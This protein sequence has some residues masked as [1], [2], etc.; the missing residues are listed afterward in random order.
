MNMARKDKTEWIL[1]PETERD[2][3]SARKKCRRMVA[4]SAAIS[5]GVSAIPI[6]GVDIAT[7]IGLLARLIED[8]NTEFGLTPEQI[9]RMRP[10]LRVV[11]Y[12]AL[13]GM[14]GVLVGKLVTRELVAQLLKRAGMKM[15]AKYSAKIVPVAGQMVAAAIGFTAFR[16]IGN[17]HV[18]ACVKVAGEIMRPQNGGPH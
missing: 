8:I 14:S 3:E 5:A 7:D 10:E 12:R 16:T 6:P 2:I 9:A 18:E 17:Q 13:V 11:A 15:V 4:R 1:V